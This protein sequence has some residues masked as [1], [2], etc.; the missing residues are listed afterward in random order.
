M[1]AEGKSKS[2]KTKGSQA[3]GFQR[4]SRPVR[5]RTG[6]SD[7][8]SW[9]W[10]KIAVIAVLG[11]LSATILSALGDYVN[12]SERFRFPED[13]SGL[14]VSGLERLERDSVDQV[15]ELDFGNPL[16]TVALE[17][18]RQELIAL[19]WVR[20]ATISR[21]WPDRVWVDVDERQP[22]AF[23]RLGTG[24]RSSVLVDDEG[25]LLEPL[26][27][28]EFDLPV[29]DGIARDMELADRLERVQ[30]LQRLVTDL[31]SAE[32]AYSE[33]FGQVDLS[34]PKN[35][36]VTVVHEGEVFE[37]Q[38]GDK[39]FRHRFEAFVT[40]VASWERTYG[41]LAKID[42]RFEDKVFMEPL[43]NPAVGKRR[44]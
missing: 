9:Q 40:N 12:E 11:V 38:M 17:E 20:G 14:A 28:V 1:A 3:D 7:W 13:G 26:P 37:L 10:K 8:R 43:E 34:D 21:I 18:R 22:I 25:V 44:R 29:A 36:V 23:L 2:R 42:L 15:F 5:V 24:R 41:K 16:G 39:M 27:G 19:P 30:L 32:P 31:D 6:I 35:A 4:R 33:R